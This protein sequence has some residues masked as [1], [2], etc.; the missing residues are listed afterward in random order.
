MTPNPCTSTVTPATTTMSLLSTS[1]VAG[2]FR[3]SNPMR[4]ELPRP[5]NEL[6]TIV[7]AAIHITRLE[8]SVSVTNWEMIIIEASV[9][10]DMMARKAI[11][12]PR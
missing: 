10:R 8:I 7:A 3:F 6:T 2:H 11:A 1:T 12:E 9:T 5:M 4:M